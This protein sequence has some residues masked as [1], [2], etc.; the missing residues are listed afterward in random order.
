MLIALQI[1]FS[2]KTPLSPLPLWEGLMGHYKLRYAERQLRRDQKP[3][4]SPKVPPDSF[5]GPSTRGLKAPPPRGDAWVSPPSLSV[6]LWA[7]SLTPDRRRSSL[8]PRDKLHCNNQVW[9]Q[10]PQVVIYFYSHLFPFFISFILYIFL[11]NIFMLLY[12]YITIDNSKQI[13]V[14]A[15]HCNL[16]FQNK[17]YIYTYI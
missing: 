2:C 17:P 15:F 9:V 8:W 4:K 13:Y 14:P 6:V 11:S 10:H 1:S 3:S 5:L 16:I 7:S 12:Y